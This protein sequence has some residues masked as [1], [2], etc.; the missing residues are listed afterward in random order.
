MRKSLVILIVVLV[1]LVAYL[2]GSMIAQRPSDS[3]DPTSY[4]VP[5]QPERRTARRTEDYDRRIDAL[6]KEMR[7]ANRSL[8]EAITELTAELRAARTSQSAATDDGAIAQSV[9]QWAARVRAREPDIVIDA[10]LRLRERL[11]TRAL[12]NEKAAES[13][14]GPIVGLLDSNE[15]QAAQ[16]AQVAKARSYREG[17]EAC[18]VA[19]KALEAVR[20]LDDLARWRAAN[21]EGE[22]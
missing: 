17:A 3:S 13:A 22:F 16:A 8:R 2:T 7:D 4:D 12:A 5:S 21:N 19:C 9:E 14:V 10:C 18:R 1:G 20:T 15:L 11:L 6:R